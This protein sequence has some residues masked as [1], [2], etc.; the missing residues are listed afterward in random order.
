MSDIFREVDEDLRREQFKKLWD[1][2][3]TYVLG[4]AVLIVLVVA[5]YKFWEYWE[6]RQAAASGDRFVAA[7]RLAE[8]GKHEEAA[9]ALEA[10]VAD[11]SGGYP[12]LAGFRAGAE[13][14]AAGDDAGAVALYDAIAQ[15]SG[16]PALI[17]DMAR[18]R[19]ALILSDSATVADLNT[20][21]GD[22]A[23]TG[24]PW[25]QN[26]REILGLAAWRV[27]DLATARKYFD[28]ILADKEA[29]QDIRSRAQFMLA[30]IDARQGAP[31]AETEPEG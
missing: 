30:L 18:L 24:N 14:L 7:V 8:E 28:E 5:G 22:L 19:A 21:I 10:I 27:D 9:T 3:G 2:F 4:A 12:I 31:A 20:R 26:A 23:A 1:R 29:A 13:K 17:R 15:R 16:T 25:R 6:T 11:G